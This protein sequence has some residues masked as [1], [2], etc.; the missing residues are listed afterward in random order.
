MS[1]VKI[2]RTLLAADLPLLSLVPATRIMAGVLPQ[3]TALPAVSVTEVSTVELPHI[4]AQSPTT[5][6][7]ARI[8]VTVMAADY[9]AQKALLDAVRKA[10]NYQRGV[11]GGIVVTSVRRGSNG[12]DFVDADAGFYMQSVDFHVIYHE[13]N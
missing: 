12:P 9:P 6:V 3:A 13:A 4:D 11:V 8:Q 5:L 7:D 2:I 10:V 1:G